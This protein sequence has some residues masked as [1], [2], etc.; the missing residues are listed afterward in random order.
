ME[1]NTP[2]KKILI[3]DDLR[4]NIDVLRAVLVNYTKVAALGGTQAL[5]VARSESPPDLILLDIMMPDMDGY[6]VCRRLKANEKTRDIPIIFLTAKVSVE[7]EAKGLTLGA[8]DYI[9]KPISPPVV[10]ARVATHLAMRDAYGQLEQQYTALREM[11]QLR[12]DVEAITRHDLKSPIDGILGC[13]EMMVKQHQTLSSA[14]MGRFSQLIRDSARQLREMVNLSLNLLKMEQGT[15]EVTLEPI[16]LLPI[17]RRIQSDNQEMV[18]RKRLE[19]LL[20]VDGCLDSP[21]TAFFI[22]G[23]ATLCYTMLA[24]LYRNALEAS[25]QGQQVSVSLE[26]GEKA[27]VA[28]HNAGVVPEEMRLNFFKKYATFGKKGGTGLGT[29][30]ARLMAKTQQGEIQMHSSAEAGTTVTITLQTVMG[31]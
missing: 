22:L 3:V 26:R 11:E 16:D 25:E 31:E 8:V 15:Y 30:S 2:P 5:E 28:I 21:E 17:L 12:K 24:N 1:S 19:I 20:Q 13:A 10:L 27:V 4:E 7:D 23:D 29:Y 14:D 9:T 18:E 6:E